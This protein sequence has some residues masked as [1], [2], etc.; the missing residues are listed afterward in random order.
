MDLGSGNYGVDPYHVSTCAGGIAAFI[1][2]GPPDD[3]ANVNFI[4]CYNRGNINSTNYYSGGILGAAEGGSDVYRE[5][6]NMT[7]CYNTGTITAKNNK[8][9]TVLGYGVNVVFSNCYSSYDIQGA[10]EGTGFNLKIKTSPKI[11]F[12]PK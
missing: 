6:V 7:N 1:Y 12:S 3:F 11:G 4:N 10:G 8:C 9:G 2:T 5:T